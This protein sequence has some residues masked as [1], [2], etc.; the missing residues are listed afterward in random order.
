MSHASGRNDGFTRKAG[1]VVV[2]IPTVEELRVTPHAAAFQ[3]VIRHC[4]VSHPKLQ[5][6]ATKW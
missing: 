6:N 4:L 3:A 2:V 5:R 1:D